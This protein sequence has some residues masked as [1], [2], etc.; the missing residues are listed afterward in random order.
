MLQMPQDHAAP[1]QSINQAMH[2]LQENGVADCE[3]TNAMSFKVRFAIGLILWSILVGLGVFKARSE[4]PPCIPVVKGTMGQ[5]PAR[6]FYGTLGRHFYWWCAADTTKVYGFSCLHNGGCNE[7]LWGAVL[8]SLN[9]S[10]DKAKSIDAAWAKNVTLDLATD[11]TGL[12]AE[13]TAIYAAN[14]KDW[15]ATPIADVW[16]VKTNGTSTTRPAYQ[17]SAGVVGLKEVARAP[18]GTVCDLTKPTAP[19]TGGDIRAQWQGGP[20]GVVTICSKVVQ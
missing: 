1:N 16:K 17:L 6:A 15:T 5:Y 9:A 8:I 11:T 20:D 7:A 10:T 14:W 3:R 12:A 19:A 4:V 2:A 13:R 18:V